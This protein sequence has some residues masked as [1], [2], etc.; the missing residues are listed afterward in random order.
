MEYFPIFLLML[1]VTA[2]CARIFTVL[3]HE[4]GHAIPALL[5]T[6]EKVT[7]YVGSY[8]NPKKN[9]RFT[10]GLL[11]LYIRY[12]PLPWKT[13]VCTYNAKGLSI[14]YR[15]ICT[16]AGP[17]ISSI[18]A[19]IACYSAFHYDLH[20][21][22]KFIFI[23]FFIS[24]IIDLHNLIPSSKTIKLNDGDIIYNDGSKLK[25]LFY[26]KRFPSDYEQAIK[27]YN[28]NNFKEA[29]NLFNHILE[30]SLK[31]EDIYRLAITSYLQTKEFDKGKRII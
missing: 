10:I 17:L 4:L 21:S 6:K 30:N 1:F 9:I 16:L 26:L 15:I 5:L 11:D 12:Y 28:E 18:I 27:L 24:A 22:L 19:V 13:G 7:V 29:G 3:F 25:K 20:G 8:G 31:E 23:V 2:L 14:N